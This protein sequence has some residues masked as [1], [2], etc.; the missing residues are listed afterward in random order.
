MGRARKRVLVMRDGN[1]RAWAY[2]CMVRV[3]RVKWS[4]L[5]E[6]EKKR[7]SQR[8]VRGSLLE[9]EVG[10]LGRCS[11]EPSS[12]ILTLTTFLEFDDREKG[13]TPGWS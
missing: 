5:R 6:V 13:W 12:L 7:V 1:S 4:A 3:A 9:V 8:G 11:T 10:A 2:W